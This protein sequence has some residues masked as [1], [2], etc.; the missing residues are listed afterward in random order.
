MVPGGCLNEMSAIEKTRIQSP[1]ELV[2]SR[3]VLAPPTLRK[4]IGNNRDQPA[5]KHKKQAEPR[6]RGQRVLVEV[7]L[8]PVCQ[9]PRQSR[10]FGQRRNEDRFD[11]VPAVECCCCKHLFLAT[12]E[13]RKARGSG[14][15]QVGGGGDFEIGPPLVN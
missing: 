9:R 1:T 5:L 14:A 3:S 4:V 10:K 2:G 12:D 15:L 11:G 7:K 8:F 13:N 6:G